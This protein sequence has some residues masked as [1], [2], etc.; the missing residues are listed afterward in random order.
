MPHTKSIRIR[1][2]GRCGCWIACFLEKVCKGVTTTTNYWATRKQLNHHHCHRN[3]WSRKIQWKKP[4]AQQGP[5]VNLLLGLRDALAEG[6]RWT[7]SMLDN[8]FPGSCS[9]FHSGLRMLPGIWFAMYEVMII[10]FRWWLR[11][12]DDDTC[13]HKASRG[14]QLALQSSGQRSAI[15]ALWLLR[16]L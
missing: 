1:S 11:N 2:C 14:Q 4:R 8:T 16:V 5:Y 9:Y 3:H 13:N 10:S 12:K 15:S 7:S 6:G